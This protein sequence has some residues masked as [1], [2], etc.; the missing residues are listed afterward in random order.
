[1]FHLNFFYVELNPVRIQLTDLLRAMGSLLFLFLCLKFTVIKTNKIQHYAT[2]AIKRELK[3]HSND[4]PLDSYQH[5]RFLRRILSDGYFYD[6]TSKMG[7]CTIFIFANKI[8]KKE[9]MKQKNNPIEKI[10]LYQRL[11]ILIVCSQ[12]NAILNTVLYLMLQVFVGIK[13]EQQCA[14]LQYQIYKKEISKK[15]NS[16]ITLCLCIKRNIL[17]LSAMKFS[18]LNVSLFGCYL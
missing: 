18:R 4:I 1:M 8:Q 15:R 16:L 5:L 13:L 17:T 9:Y 7:E 6:F 3:N 2:M 11:M 10:I 14:C 12:P